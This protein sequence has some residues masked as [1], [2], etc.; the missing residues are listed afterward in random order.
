MT[1]ERARQIAREELSGA[2]MQYGKLLSNFMGEVQNTHKEFKD[3]N[4]EVLEILRE[5]NENSTKWREAIETRFQKM[6][7]QIKDLGTKVEPVVAAFTPEVQA[8]ISFT[9]KL[10]KVFWS[11]FKVLGVV[12]ATILA[13][14]TGLAALK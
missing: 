13:I 2:A 6:E 10:I 11:T 5:Q 9:K 14:K 3:S 7:D 4:K 12:G 8:N 1:E